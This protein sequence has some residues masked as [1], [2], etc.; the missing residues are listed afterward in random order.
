M[1]AE[2]RKAVYACINDRE[3]T[4]LKK[5]E[6]QAVSIDGDIGD[7]LAGLNQRKG[8]NMLAGT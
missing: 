8:G 5:I 7:V 6:H 4:G 1:T 3:K 2:N